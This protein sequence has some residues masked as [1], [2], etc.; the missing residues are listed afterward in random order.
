MRVCLLV[1]T[2]SAMALAQTPVTT[3]SP[4]TSAAA[5]E[6]NPLLATTQAETTSA[7]A[8]RLVEWL[9]DVD[10]AVDAAKARSAPLVVI[11]LDE[12]AP[13]DEQYIRQSLNEMQTR[14]FLADFAA[15]RIDVTTEAGKAAFAK[16]GAAEPPLTQVFSAEG[17]LLDSFPG[18]AIPATEFRARLGRSVAYLAAAKAASAAGAGP[19]EKQAMAEARLELSTRDKAVPIID[20]LIRP[21]VQPSGPDL[22]LAV[23]RLHVLRGRA[24]TF[25]DPAAAKA[26]FEQA[27]KLAPNDDASAGEA[28]LALANLANVKKDYKAAHDLDAQYIQRFPKGPKIA[29]A[30]VAKALQEWTGLDE[31]PTARATLEKFI[32]DYPD[33]PGVVT[34]KKWL[35]YMAGPTS[36]P[37]KPK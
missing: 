12:K 13:A 17:E 3:S 30:Y 16:T 34:A 6:E 32:K 23:A 5:V 15:A 24:L 35:E 9:T 1:L 21:D 4:T 36:K 31:R 2:L 37:S 22:V 26:E 29:Q 19:K 11:Y 10:Q 7:P 20:E 28:L 18:A 14:K 8:E 25:K 27:A 33:D